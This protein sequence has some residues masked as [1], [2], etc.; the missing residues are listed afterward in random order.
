MNT[1][2]VC[3]EYFIATFACQFL[4]AEKQNHRWVAGGVLGEQDQ[5]E[6]RDDLASE[7]SWRGPGRGAAICSRTLGAGQVPSGN[8]QYHDGY[9]DP[10]R[11][12]A[13]LVACGDGGR[14][15]QPGPGDLLGEIGGEDLVGEMG[16]DLVGE[17][18]G[19]ICWARLMA[20]WAARCWPARWASRDLGRDGRAE[21]QIVSLCNDSLLVIVSLDLGLARDGQT[22]LLGD[23]ATMSEN[24]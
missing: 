22:C 24:C 10:L 15:N 21:I 2:F 18:D 5:G 9:A 20:R 14:S 17:I 16:G 7:R 19:G 3:L 1:K 4:V 23:F 6:R 12:T 8:L 13:D 11:R